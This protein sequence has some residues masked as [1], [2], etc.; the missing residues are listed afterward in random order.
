MG[1]AGLNPVA[2]G[3]EIRFD[4]QFQTMKTWPQPGSIKIVDQTVLIKLNDK[5]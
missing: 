4:N 5:K 2:K 1:I 3:D